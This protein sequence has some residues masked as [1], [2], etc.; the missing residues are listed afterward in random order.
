MPAY[1]SDEWI[2]DLDTALRASPAGPHPQPGGAP[3][4]IETVV[5]GV[6]RYRVR[7]DERGASARAADAADAPAD[8]RL[9]TDLATAAAIARGAENAQI[10]L[11][12]GRL[13]L[14]GDVTALPRAADAARRARR[15]DRR[16][17]RAHD[18]PVRRR[19]RLPARCGVR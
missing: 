15:R 12:G 16:T 14:G 1:L 8:V 2:A 18:V 13:Q 7:F 10:A 5:R 9:T 3:L 19:R 4:E 17:P 11:A 6:A